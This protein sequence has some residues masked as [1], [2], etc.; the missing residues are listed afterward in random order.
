M[1]QPWGKHQPCRQVPCRAKGPDPARRWTPPRPGCPP[2]PLPR[3][4]PEPDPQRVSAR[5]A[6]SSAG[7]AWAQ[8]TGRALTG[9]VATR[10]GSSGLSRERRWA[11]AAG[12]LEPL[13]A[14]ACG[15]ALAP[16]LREA[17]VAVAGLPQGVL[18]KGHLGR[19]RLGPGD[20]HAVLAGREH[21]V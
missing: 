17:D 13:P 7:L 11:R 3:P 1:D 4:D 15:F 16:E 10:A 2:A 14:A 21:A 12:G 18:L 6:L 5:V 20:Q 19:M 9:V 8:R